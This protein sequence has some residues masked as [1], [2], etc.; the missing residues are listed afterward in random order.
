MQEIV[1]IAQREKYQLYIIYP[2]RQNT[3][4]FI[5]TLNM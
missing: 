3:T 5:V 4:T 1:S 2:Y